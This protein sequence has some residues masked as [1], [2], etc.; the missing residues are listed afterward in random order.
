MAVQLPSTSSH[1]TTCSC[2]SSCCQV[3]PVST[4][5]QGKVFPSQPGPLFT[6]LNLVD[7]N[8]I[9][10]YNFIYIILQFNSW[11]CQATSS[12]LFPAHA[13]DYLDYLLI[14]DHVIRRITDKDRREKINR[15][16]KASTYQNILLSLECFISPTKI[17]DQNLISPGYFQITSNMGSFLLQTK[18]IDIL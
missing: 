16:Q 14:S 18:N 1:Q 10:F 8:F 17:I 5:V 7:Q 4:T 13:G 9:L 2:T 3:S 12:Y 15:E 6:G 11:G